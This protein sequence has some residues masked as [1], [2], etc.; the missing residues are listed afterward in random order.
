[1]TDMNS[2]LPLLQNTARALAGI[3]LIALGLSFGY[4]FFT[5][6][7]LGKVN[8]WGGLEKVHWLF[9]PITL[10]VT[11]FL[12]HFPPKT[13]NL[14]KVRSAGYVHLLWGPVFFL[15]SL[16]LMVS[17]A[18][19]LGL[20]GTKA[21]NFVLTCGRPDI[22]AAITYQPPTSEWAIG[23]YKFPILRKAKRVVFRLLTQDIQISKNKAINPFA[24]SGK[25]AGRKFLYEDEEDR[26]EDEREEAEAAAKQQAEAQK[27]LQAQQQQQQ[28]QKAPGP[29][30]K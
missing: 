29:P 26:L 21:M 30:K 13:T 24:E 16:M 11:P 10:F 23:T 18:D 2:M 22:P 27:Q 1:M 15:V 8:Y 3:L 14:I 19:F 4:K 17:G 20:P 5:A 7:F 6:S 12:V 28:Q 25:K 9:H